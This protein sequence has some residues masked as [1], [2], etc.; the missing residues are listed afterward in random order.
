MNSNFTHGQSL[1]L[2]LLGKFSNKEVYGKLV[3]I[4][5]SEA[6]SGLFK[7]ELTIIT[8]NKKI[9]TE[10]LCGAEISFELQSTSNA[11]EKTE[12]YFCGMIETVSLT[13]RYNPKNSINPAFEYKLQVVPKLSNLLKIKHSRVF[14]KPG[15]KLLDVITQILK[16][17]NINHE[18]K[19]KNSDKFLAETCIQYNETDY[20]FLYRLLHSAGIYYF[21]KHEKDKHILLIANQVENY[22]NLPPLSITNI[23]KN[24]DLFNLQ[25]LSAQYSMH[26]TDF[27]LNAFAYSHREEA[28]EESYSHAAHTM[29]N[30]ENFKNIKSEESVYMGEIKDLKQV[31]LLNESITTAQQSLAEYIRGDSSYPCFAVGGKFKLKGDAFVHFKEHEYVIAEMSFKIYNFISAEQQCANNFVA[32]PK[33]QI[34]TNSKPVTKPIIQGLHIALIVDDQGSSKSQE[35]YSDEQGRVYIKLLWGKKNTICKANVLSTSN[36]YT[37]PRIGSLAYVLFPHN[38]L[39][40]DFP[41]VVGISN[42]DLLSFTNKDE[43]YKNIYMVSPGSSDKEIYNFISFHDQQDK[44]EIQVTAKK[45]I[46]YDIANDETVTI[47]NNSTHSVKNIRKIIIEEGNDVLDVNKG[48]I[49]IDVKEGN[50]NITCKGKTSIKA[51]SDISIESKANLDLKAGGKITLTSQKDTEIKGQNIT[52]KSL[53]NITQKATGAATYEAGTS[54]DIKSNAKIGINSTITEIKGKANVKISAPM[55][56]I[57]M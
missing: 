53:S 12:R 57:S 43:W 9:A 23:S 14:Q 33:D 50:Y 44:Q 19:V 30:T 21:F 41:I 45:D 25:G 39:Y 10:V 54:I 34:F 38:N 7:Y 8:Q 2:N 48:D 40:N 35:P 13:K 11:I 6:I 47:K 55:T 46:L 4:S 29:Q 27:E 56:K 52:L 42:E 20:D 36:N 3:S 31:S 37:I 5:G 49:L 22:F 1:T 16:E 17:H 28:S 15:Q 26:A 18:I 24:R 51:D 32:I